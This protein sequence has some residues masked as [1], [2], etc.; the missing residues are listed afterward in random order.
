LVAIREGDLL[1]PL[2][3]LRSHPDPG[4]NEDEASHISYIGYTH[5]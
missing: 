4:H 3:V 5:L 1:L 2:S